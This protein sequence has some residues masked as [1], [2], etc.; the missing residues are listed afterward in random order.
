[1]RE[2]LKRKIPEESANIDQLTD[3]EIEELYE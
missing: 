2:E 3:A 1:M